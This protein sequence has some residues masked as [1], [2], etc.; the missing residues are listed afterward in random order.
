[1]KS[2]RHCRSSSSGAS[3]VTSPAEPGAPFQ[4]RFPALI[5]T[6]VYVVAA[7]S[8][9][10]PMLSGHIL[11]GSDQ[12]NVGYALRAYAAQGMQHGGHIPQWNPFIFGGMPLWAVPGHFD[13]FYPT[14]WLRWFLSAD[15]V[16]TLGF[17]IHLVVAGIAMYAL[18]RTLRASWTA[19][20]TGGLAYE[21]TGILA[22]QVSPGHDGK[23]FAAALAPFAF[24]ALVRA[25]RHGRTGGF[26]WFALVIGLDMLTP[27]YLAV[28]YLLIACGLFTLWLV[29]LDPERARDRS[30]LVPIAMTALAA[31]LGLG[32]A[33]IELLPVQHMVA[34]TARGAGG[35]SLGYDYA[36]SYAMPPEELMTVILPQ[37]NGVLPEH[38]WGQNFFKDHTEYLGAIVVT[39][40]ILGVPAAGKRGLLLPLG[41]LGVLFLLVAWGGHTPFYRLWYLLPKM[42]QFRA[43]GLAFYLVALVGCVLAG[44]GVDHLLLG[45][46]KR[47][48][49]LAVVGVIGVIA[50]LATAGMLQGITESLALPPM[51]GQAQGNAVALQAG[52]LRLLVVVLAGGAALFLIQRRLLTGVAAAVALL[53]VVGGD[54]WSILREF[55]KWLP[56]ASVTFADDVFTTAMK[57]TP[58][59]FRAYSPASPDN[60]DPQGRAQI[61]S[62]DV[63]PAASLMARGVPSLLG[64]HGMESQSFDALLGGKNVW[65]Y[66]FSS[67]IWDLY[68]VKYVALTQDTPQLPGY[69]KIRGPIEL[70]DPVGVAVQGVLFERDSAIRWARVV[71]AAVKLPEDQIALTVTNPGFPVN[72]YVL[73]PDT[74][75]VPGAITPSKG[76][77]T[78]P[79][80]AVKASLSAWTPGAISVKLDGTDARPTWLLV[81]ENWYPDWHATVDGKPAPVLRGNGAMIAVELPSGAKDVTLKY[82]I[83]T[84]HQGTW[85]TVIAVVL[86]ALLLFAD[87]PRP[88]MANA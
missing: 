9:M 62:L 81:A 22:S 13:V 55:P 29:F 52:G 43:P 11:G 1:M 77:A 6:V 50:V 57:Q 25:I 36:T 61:N 19:A 21:L 4:P 12:I 49:L 44:F 28:Y 23:L 63:Y 73:F 65:K 33:A 47:G 30:P 74:A 45:Q 67:N 16:L 76:M 59:P 58:M 84:Y 69:H 56:P 24:V 66:Q 85:I 34:Y 37:F 41:G 14:A 15:R 80:A 7:L 8:L 70:G 82:D 54:N 72:G 20:V 71:P 10:A 68:A 42:G 39:L 51:L 60:P 83:A 86:V 87:R 2:E 38:Y 46:V 17:F 32:I 64:Y 31:V 35:A 27:H 5:A 53:V 88:R 18:L 3:R 40:M 75:A 48:L 79:P 78:P 26:G